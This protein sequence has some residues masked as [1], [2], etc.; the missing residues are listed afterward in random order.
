M[1]TGRVFTGSVPRRGSRSASQI[2]PRSGIRAALDRGE[3]GVH[4]H[5]FLADLP[6]RLGR[7]LDAQLGSRLAVHAL[8]GAADIGGTRL[9]Q[10]SDPDE[11]L[12]GLEL[13]NRW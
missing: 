2:Y 10:P 4:A 3:L 1:S 13:A 11:M 12:G 8:D 6:G 5:A 7:S 9:R